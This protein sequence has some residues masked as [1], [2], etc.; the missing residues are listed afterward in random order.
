MDKYFTQK[1]CDKCGGN[2]NGGR[3]LSAFNLDVLCMGCKEKEKQDPDYQK[4]VEADHE[5]IRCGNYNY[6][7]Y[8]KNNG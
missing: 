3:T 7:G 2:L 6:E 5:Q 8:R 4:A 1:H